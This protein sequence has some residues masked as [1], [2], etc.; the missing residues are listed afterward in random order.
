[1]LRS[2]ATGCLLLCHGCMFSRTCHSC[3]WNTR[4]VLLFTQWVPKC[5]LYFRT[6]AV[7]HMSVCRHMVDWF[8]NV[9]TTKKWRQ[10]ACSLFEHRSLYLRPG[11]GERAKKIWCL[12][13]TKFCWIGNINIVVKPSNSPTQGQP[14]P[15][16][17]R[18]K[19]VFGPLLPTGNIFSRV[20]IGFM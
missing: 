7:F 15:R 4:T 11:R 14:S 5:S 19:V 18:L 16:K 1:M 9:T 8:P 10:C 20:G 12:W 17:M 13:F 6:H 2:L 3:P